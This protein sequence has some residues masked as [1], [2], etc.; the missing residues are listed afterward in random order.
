C[1]WC[2][3]GIGNNSKR[4]LN[5]VHPNAAGQKLFLSLFPADRRT[6]AG[7][8]LPEFYVL[9]G[10]VSQ[11]LYFKQLALF[12]ALDFN[13]FAADRSGKDNFFKFLVAEERSSRLNGVTNIYQN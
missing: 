8:I 12:T 13:D 1:L 3:T 5:Q 11:Y 9:K 6:V 7:G 10:F 4:S 2:F